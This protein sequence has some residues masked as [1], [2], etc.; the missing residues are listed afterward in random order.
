MRSDDVRISTPSV[1]FLVFR[2]ARSAIP[3]ECR[4]ADTNGHSR[5]HIRQAA[6]PMRRVLPQREFMRPEEMS[7]GRPSL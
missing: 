4:P 5:P 1:S 6:P 7:H 3:V 2:N